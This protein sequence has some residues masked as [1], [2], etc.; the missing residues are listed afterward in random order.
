MAGRKV[1]WVFRCSKWLGHTRL[2][3]QSSGKKSRVPTC[4]YP[5]PS[6]SHIKPFM[7][8]PCQHHKVRSWTR[9]QCQLYGWEG[10]KKQEQFVSKELG[11]SSCAASWGAMDH[12]AC[13]IL[14]PL[15]FPWQSLFNTILTCH[16]WLLF[17]HDP[18]LTGGMLWDS[19]R[20]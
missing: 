8:N 18:S 4:P 19:S 14:C 13:R 1:I 20:Q 17:L 12:L 9:D 2:G 5:K 11:G 15:L 3:V 10:A 6:F 16:W 7:K